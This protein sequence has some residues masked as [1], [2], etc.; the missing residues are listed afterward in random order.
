MIEER[1]DVDYPLTD[2]ISENL[3]NSL[4]FVDKRIASFR[5]L[6]EEGAVLLILREGADPVAIRAKAEKVIEVNRPMRPQ[7]MT[8]VLFDNSTAEVPCRE[9]I[10]AQLLTRGDVWEHAPG[11]FSLSGQVLEMYQALERH[12]LALAAAQG[13]TEIILPVTTSLQT[14]N[15]SDFFKR[16]PQFANFICTLSEDADSIL[17]FSD[18]I[19]GEDRK[20]RFADYLNEPRFMCRSAICL[21]CYSMFADR[22]LTPAEHTSLTVIGKAFRNEA[23]NVS[24]LERLH[25]F[26]MREIIY[27]GDREF[28]AQRLKECAEWFIGFMRE[29]GINGR[30]QTANDPFFSENIQALQFYQIAEQSKFEV[31]LNNPFSGNAV[32]VGSI[33]NHGAHF[34]KAYRITLPDGQFV[35]TGC[36]GFGY[37]R[38]IF[39]TLSQFGLTTAAWPAGLREFWFG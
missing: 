20:F 29:H 6:R 33:N 30:I 35:T 15:Q 2:R 8:H 11:I 34:S 25:E 19:S 17:D 36:V 14:L 9:D 18:K 13:A 23:A 24:T 4:A 10:F 37:E 22:I 21:S 16:T 5:L 26:S 27:F 3:Q 38:F 32:S 12:V 7:D 39:L 28:V 1:I 31:R